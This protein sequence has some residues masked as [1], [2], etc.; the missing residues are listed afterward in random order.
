M[1]GIGAPWQ[2]YGR[3]VGMMYPVDTTGEGYSDLRK[4]EKLPLPRCERVWYNT[5]REGP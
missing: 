1:M 5:S 2:F 3:Q 4:G